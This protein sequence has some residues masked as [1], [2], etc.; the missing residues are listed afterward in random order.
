MI[1]M[2][3]LFPLLLAGARMHHTHRLARCLVGAAPAAGVAESTA[4]C[5]VCNMWRLGA[6]TMAH[7]NTATKGPAAPPATPSLPLAPRCYMHGRCKV[8]AAAWRTW[9]SQ[10]LCT[11]LSLRLAPQ[12]QG[13]LRVH[14]DTKLHLPHLLLPPPRIRG[15]LP[16]KWRWHQHAALSH[17]ESMWR[18]L[19]T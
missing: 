6:Q 1:N 4:P 14:A 12:K 13:R 18:P 5:S 16:T 3:H 10:M 19:H 9:A 8:I 17:M 11:R 15:R 2:Q 7:V